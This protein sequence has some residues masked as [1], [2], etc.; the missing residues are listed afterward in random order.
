MVRCSGDLH[1]QRVSEREN[2]IKCHDL[3]TICLHIGCHECRDQHICIQIHTYRLGEAWGRLGE[4]FGEAWGIYEEKRWKMQAK[5]PL[6]QFCTY[7]CTTTYIGFQTEIHFKP[8]ASRQAELRPGRFPTSRITTREDPHKQ[9]YDQGAYP[10]G[11]LRPGSWLA[12][13]LAGGI[14]TREP[15]MRL[16]G[17]LGGW[18]GG[19]LAEAK[20]GPERPR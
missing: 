12:G 13:W 2:Y 17:W 20:R 11:E 6:P 18:L 3:Q 1:R 9:N 4:C 15:V 8:S 7:I 19:W 10:Q 5:L 14:T 16:A